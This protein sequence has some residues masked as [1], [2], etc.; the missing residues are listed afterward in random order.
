MIKFNH[1]LTNQEDLVKYGLVGYIK[2]D[3][4]DSY[5]LVIGHIIVNLNL[6]TYDLNMNFM[7]LIL[8]EWPYDLKLMLITSYIHVLKEFKYSTFIF[9]SDKFQGCKF[10]YKVLS[11]IKSIDSIYING[12]KIEPRTMSLHS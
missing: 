6:T 7:K 12:L 2:P 5:L 4:L 9:L 10:P 11:M 3:D 1:Y 8:E